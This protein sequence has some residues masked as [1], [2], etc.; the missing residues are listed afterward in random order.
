MR[1][2]TKRIYCLMMASAIAFTAIAEENDTLPHWGAQLTVNPS[3][4]PTMDREIKELVQRNGALTIGG[5]LRHVSLPSDGDLYAQDYGYPTFIFGA[6]YNVYNHV[7]LHRDENADLGKGMPVDYNTALGNSFSFY[8]GFERAFFR[9]PRWEA[10]YQFNIGLGLSHRK[11]NRHTQVDNLMISSNVSIYFGAAFHAT[12]RF[13]KDWGLKGGIEFNHHSSGTLARP[14]KGSN[15]IGPTI[16][17]VYYPYYEE[18]LKAP[19]YKKTTEFTPSD[20]W[21]FT[22]NAGLCTLY[23]DWLKTQFE[24][25]PTDPDY[26]SNDF[27]HYAVYS[28]Q[29]D[30]MRRHHRRWASGVGLDLYYLTYMNHIREM[31]RGNGTRH[32]PLSIGIS[33]KHEAFY[34]N[35][36]LAMSF[37]FYALRLVGKSAG[38][39]EQPFYETIGLKYHFPKLNN[40][41]LG[42]Y[43]RAHAFKADHTGISLS[44]PIYLNK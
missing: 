2:I 8:A 28:L 42:A 6:N 25:E 17:I 16:G 1:R 18:L 44:V 11:Y 9:T 24:T 13:A 10:D 23:Q 4:V 21:N 35:I 5:Q 7:N 41:A 27:R 40:I 31:D 26:R 12:Y 34:H 20:Y 29:A 14:N 19:Q 43:V 3:V 32:C 38:K 30:Y 33:A 22:V 15:T 39:V 37:G 36:S